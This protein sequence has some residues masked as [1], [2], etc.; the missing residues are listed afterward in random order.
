MKKIGVYRFNAGSC[1]GCDVEILG[2]L[3][4]RFKLSGLGIEIVD[5]P[6]E[7]NVLLVT[8]PVNIKV[9]EELKQAREKLKTPK[10]VVAIGS[11]AISKGIY[12]DSYAVVGP[13]DEIVSVDTYVAGCPPRPQA[14]CAAISEILAMEFKEVWPAPK[15]FRGELKLDDEKC[16]GC[17]ACVQVCPAGA[18]EL[19]DVDDK[20]NV[21][22]RY[23]KCTFCGACEESCPEGAISF[24]SQY[25]LIV[26]D[27]ET[28][29]TATELELA[30]C[31]VCGSHFVPSR[32]LRKALERI[33]E[34][35]REYEEFREVLDQTVKT[36]PKCRK[37][38][39][40]VKR[41]KEVLV[42]LRTKILAAPR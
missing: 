42:R 14:I 7:A 18:A 28:A 20:R 16:T 6:D 36:C 3:A 21:K 26:R 5:A 31:A 15:E 41:A 32:Q 17:G 33:T 4:P 9:S 23:S 38:M 30:N 12:E 2:A 13:A 29:V 37:T 25:R 22:F 8:G 19:V 35:V 39:E 10:I 34:N 1:N 27:K 11:C 40:N 24:T